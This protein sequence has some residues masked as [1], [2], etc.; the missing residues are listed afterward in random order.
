MTR[1]PPLSTVVLGAV[2]AFVAS[3]CFTSWYLLTSD[4]DGLPCKEF[5]P[6]NAAAPRC[7]AEYTCIEG[8]CRK[9]GVKAKGELCDGDAQCQAGLACRDI[10]ENELCGTQFPQDVCALGRDLDDEPGL[11]CRDVCDPDVLDTDQC[12]PGERCFL[13]NEGK[14]AG[15]CQNGSCES[16]S[17]CGV[18]GQRPNLCFEAANDPGPS[19]LCFHRC[20]PLGCEPDGTCDSCPAVDLNGDGTPE[21]QGCEP[22][23]FPLQLARVACVPAGTVPADQPCDNQNTFCE[24]GAWCLIG[25]DGVGFCSRWCDPNGG[26]PGCDAAHGTCSFA[27]DNGIDVVGFCN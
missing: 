22:I 21:P 7:L 4:P 11:R 23:E 10:W 24:P 16:D 3:G 18:N 25:S 12:A 19:G 1:A 6:Q 20:D 2:V 13:D 15:Y 27:F 8:L 17:D 26:A 9:A 5:D 14:V